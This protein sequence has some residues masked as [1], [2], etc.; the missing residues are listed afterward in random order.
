MIC[1]P[2]CKINLGLSIIEKRNDGFHNLESIMYPVNLCDMLE[3]IIAPD[4]QFEFNASGIDI[5]GKHTDNLVV[6]AYK[7]MLSEHQLS[8]VKIHLH[9][10]I[11][12]GAGLG[13][14]SSDAAFTIKTLNNLFN[15][16]LSNVA[17]QDYAREIGADCAFFIENK[18][19]FVTKKGD[20][21]SP[22]EPKL[23]N[24]YITIVKPN[25]QI[26]TPEAY[27]WIT[28]NFTK[29]SLQDVINEPVKNWNTI[30]NNDFENEVFDRF[31]IIK[32]IKEKLYKSG[33]VYASLSG[34]GSALYGIFEEPVSLQN[35]FQEYFYWTGMGL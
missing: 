32:N 8:P 11:P 2:N 17:M 27:S 18:P 10:I 12:A 26:S 1:F 4:N 6:K 23:K 25:I 30:L 22:I 34:S 35:E 20:Q 13:G 7:L 28:P 5:S 14:G 29:L 31:P 16:G 15:L 33:A 3:I 9:K 24:Y 21:F 19:V